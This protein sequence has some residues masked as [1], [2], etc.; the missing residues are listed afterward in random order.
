MF[1][2]NAEGYY[3]GACRTPRCG[4]NKLRSKPVTVTSQAIA[5][6]SGASKW[7]RARPVRATLAA[8]DQR[9]MVDFV[10]PDRA[11]RDS[12]SPPFPRAAQAAHTPKI[13]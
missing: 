7:Q 1:S 13:L 10:V 8:A 9:V 5:R 2:L 3:Q 12:T 11:S 6:G 4:H